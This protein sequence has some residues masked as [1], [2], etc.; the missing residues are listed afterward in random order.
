MIEQ[1]IIPIT[2]SIV[3]AWISYHYLR[4][5]KWMDKINQDHHEFQKQGLWIEGVTY[6]VANISEIEWSEERE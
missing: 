4:W 1:W 5:A 6:W 3:F 2:F